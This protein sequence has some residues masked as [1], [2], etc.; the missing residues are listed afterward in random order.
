MFLGWMYTLTSV[1][2]IYLWAIRFFIPQTAV[3]MQARIV[4]GPACQYL[5]LLWLRIR[6]KSWLTLSDYVQGS[7]TYGCSSCESESCSV[8]FTLCNPMD[9]TVQDSPGQNTGVGSCCLL[10]GIFPTQGSNPGLPRCGRIL[11]H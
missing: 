3:C 2:H 1:W 6:G 8:V 10:Q 11:Y 4:L 7:A 9:Y 5:S